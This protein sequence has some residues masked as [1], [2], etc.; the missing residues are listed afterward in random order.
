M[1]EQLPEEH[2]SAKLAQ[3][4]AIGVQIA[5]S[6]VRLRQQHTLDRTDETTRAAGAA[7]AERS[8]QHAADR[9][10]WAPALRRDWRNQADVHD[11]GRAWGAASGW[12]DTDPL[13][14]T[15]ARRVEEQLS[16]LAPNTMARY[17]ELRE[18]GWSRPDAM[19]DVLPNL[20]V[21]TNT[22]RRVFVA[23]G[24]THTAGPS[25]DAQSHADAAAAQ[26]R[27]SER[28]PDDL[29]TPFVDEHTDGMAAAV[30]WR[31][32]QASYQA[33]ADQ[34]PPEA[35]P[36]RPFT[37]WRATTNGNPHP[38]DVAATSYPHRFTRTRP[39]ASHPHPSPA[40]RRL[41]AQTRTLTR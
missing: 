32:T 24:A 6:V 2:A 23:D 21:E 20:T 19:H 7:R 41:P 28:H 33:Y 8:A 18:S 34:L 27:T 13:A 9:L 4:M 11:L 17:D 1:V 5:E 10:T 22:Q 39:A 15:A 12:A 36:D 37:A 26:A 16:E 3:F 30:P 25:A 40:T 35:G 29:S 31:D 14:D 38:A